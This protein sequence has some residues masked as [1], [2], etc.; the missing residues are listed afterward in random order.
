M[1]VSRFDPVARVCMMVP[2]TLHYDRPGTDA[3]HARE[4]VTMHSNVDSS[5]SPRHSFEFLTRWRAV[6]YVVLLLLVVAL[7][8]LTPARTSGHASGATTLQPR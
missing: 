2:A 7:I 4:T 8:Q 5:L 1:R 6:I 3:R